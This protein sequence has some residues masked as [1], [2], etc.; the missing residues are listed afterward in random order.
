MTIITLLLLLIISS[1]SLT[2]QPHTEPD[3]D[4]PPFLLWRYHPTRTEGLLPCHDWLP[5]LARRSHAPPLW[6]V[7]AAT[8]PSDGS[9]GTDERV[10]PH[11]QSPHTAPCWAED[12]T[13]RHTIT[14][15]REQLQ[16]T[17][18]SL[19]YC[20]M[21]S[22]YYSET[23]I[24]ILQRTTKFNPSARNL[25]ATQPP[26]QA[27]GVAQQPSAAQ[28]SGASPQDLLQVETRCVWN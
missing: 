11:E 2:N 12:G 25:P 28:V 19:C 8:K 13:A 16:Q 10:Q 21:S 18:L 24:F 9:E 6:T 20:E 1:P 3:A 7:H 22:F 23:V 5:P 26:V 14:A 27:A 15:G 17:V 4:V